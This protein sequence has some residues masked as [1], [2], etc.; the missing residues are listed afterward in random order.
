MIG[1]Y[2]RTGAVTSKKDGGD[3]IEH[4]RVALEAVGV[5]FTNGDKS[6]V[7]LKKAEA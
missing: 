2:E 6:G 4:I 7:K 5:T 1:R 3:W